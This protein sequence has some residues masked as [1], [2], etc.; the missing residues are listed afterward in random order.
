MKAA[1]CNERINYNQWTRSDNACAVCGNIRIMVFILALTWP[2]YPTNWNI[3]II[4]VYRPWQVLIFL[5]TSWTINPLSTQSTFLS[6]F[7]HKSSTKIYC[8]GA[9]PKRIWSGRMIETLRLCTV[10]YW[11]IAVGVRHPNWTIL[12]S[13]LHSIA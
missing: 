6:K 7:T 3:L 1:R 2:V 12:Y 10:S 4:N 11:H 13:C 8:N 9:K 5:D